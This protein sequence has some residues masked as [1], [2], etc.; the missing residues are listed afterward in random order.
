MTRAEM[1]QVFFNI[2]NAS[3]VA[4]S[5]NPAASQSIFTDVSSDAWYFEAVVY[6]ES[7]G[8]V[9][10]FPD[11]TLRP[12]E[13][14]TN[15][16]F[17]AL[18]VQFFNLEGVAESDM[19]M[20]ASSHWGAGYINLGFARGWFE[21]FGVVEAFDADAPIQRAQAVALL[22]F[23]QGRI[24]CTVAINIFLEST[25]ITIFPDLQQG[26]WSFYEVIEATFSRYYYVD[27]HS[28]EVWRRVI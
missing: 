10:G 8:I 14:I 1:I 7:R 9:Q 15:A 6:F 11:S 16:E 12:N 4:L 20:E 26:H 27:S 22:N 21:Y 24:P 28:N 17:A 18:A 5:V 23:Y 3:P 25:S 13:T 2:A 19:L